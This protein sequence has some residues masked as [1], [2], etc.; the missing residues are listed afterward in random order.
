MQVSKGSLSAAV[1]STMYFVFGGW[2][3]ESRNFT[4]FWVHNERFIKEKFVIACVPGV[5][6][7]K[8]CLSFYLDTYIRVVG[9]R[10]LEDVCNYVYLVEQKYVIPIIQQRK[11]E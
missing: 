5:F 9:L 6:W 3:F 11:Y 10:Y 2:W 7:R 1:V 8:T 4:Q